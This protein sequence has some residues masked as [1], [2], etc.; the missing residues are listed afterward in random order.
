[1]RT[2]P[3]P[4]NA[5]WIRFCSPEGASRLLASHRVKESE[6]A[7]QNKT[8]A[9]EFIP[10]HP[11][12]KSLRVAARGCKGCDLYKNATQT[13]FGKGPRHARVMLVGEQP[14]NVEDLK[15][16]PFVGPSGA[17]LRKALVE[18]GVEVD[19]VYVTNAVKHFKF[20]RKG[21][22]RLHKKPNG[23]EINA[24]KPWLEA[25]IDLVKPEIIFALGATAAHSLLGNEVRIGRDRGQ[26]LQSEW[27]GTVV[28]TE[29]PSAILRAPDPRAREQG[30]R[31][32]V[33]D[34]KLAVSHSRAHSPRNRITVSE[35][36]AGR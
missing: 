4:V 26:Y 7:K 2:T 18:A 1:M 12:L 35:E 9:S 27:A 34:L 33:S 24:C 21:K 5:T 10:H 15:G 6:M 29:H 25:E 13:V 14:G 22:I 20:E 31:N 36:S 28:I 8:D 30:F 3:T 23:G 19:D 11:S 32:L 17:L 16:E